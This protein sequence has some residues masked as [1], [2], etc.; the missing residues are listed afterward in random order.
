MFILNDCGKIQ[1]LT[2]NIWKNIYEIQKLTNNIWKNIYEIQKLTNNI[3]WKKA[4][5]FLVTIS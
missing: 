4:F 3:E 1:K 5:Y 2:K